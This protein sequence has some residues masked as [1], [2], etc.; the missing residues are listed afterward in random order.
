[1]I[2]QFF[3]VLCFLTLGTVAFS[4]SAELV[5]MKAKGGKVFLPMNLN[6]TYK[7]YV[8]FGDNYLK[9][10]DLKKIKKITWNGSNSDGYINGVGELVIEFKYSAYGEFEGTVTYKGSFVKGKANNSFSITYNYLCTNNKKEKTRY[11]IIYEGMMEDSYLSGSAK[12]E[13]WYIKDYKI[14]E[15]NK[16]SDYL[17]IDYT[18][19]FKKDKFH[20]KGNHVINANRKVENIGYF[21]DGEF[22]GTFPEEGE[23]E[24][25]DERGNF[26]KGGV[27]NFKKNGIGTIKYQ[28]GTTYTGGWLDD[29]C[30]GHG[31]CLY[32]NGDKFEGEWSKNGKITYANGDIYEG[33]TY[34]KPIGYRANYKDYVIYEQQKHGKGVLKYKS[35]KKYE[36]EFNYDF[37]HGNGTMFDATGKIEYDGEWTYNS[38]GGLPIIRALTVEENGTITT[39]QWIIIQYYDTKYTACQMKS[40]E[41]GKATLTV[42]MRSDKKETSTLITFERSAGSPFKVEVG[43]EY[44]L[45]MI[46]RKDKKVWDVQFEKISGEQTFKNRHIINYFDYHRTGKYEFEYRMQSMD[47]HG[48]KHYHLDSTVV[49]NGS[50]YYQ[51]PNK[52]DAIQYIGAADITERIYSSGIGRYAHSFTVVPNGKGKA[53]S[54]FDS[55]YSYIVGNWVNGSLDKNT[56]ATMVM[57][58]KTEKTGFWLFNGSVQNDINFY[59][60]YKFLGKTT[61]E[62][63]QTIGEINNNIRQD[64]KEYQQLKE[65]AKTAH[66]KIKSKGIDAEY[67]DRTRYFVEF[68]SGKKVYYDYVPADSEYVISDFLGIGFLK[69]SFKTFEETMEYLYI[70]VHKNK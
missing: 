38:Q 67:S 57:K 70:E 47:N 49:Y 34:G 22:V 33:A 25:T 17:F 35:G 27:K 54:L 53:I 5:E 37:I 36:G 56:Q 18:G 51:Y 2:K 3:L 11:I 14:K 41:Y 29:E 31:V 28:N 69:T 45:Q 8:Y 50:V 68:N 13:V 23:V 63:N 15:L 43:C 55:E 39:G 10:D 26:Y 46:W 44:F 4:Q 64:N 7:T 19:N 16:N 1:M 52:E 9:I 58:D 24:A 12:L 66:L 62:A 65:D 21:K 60:Y 61:E 42:P 40:S 32:A 30:S 20:G 48:E 6:V 59:K